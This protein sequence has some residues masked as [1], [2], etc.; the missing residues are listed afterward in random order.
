MEARIKNNDR[1]LK[2]SSVKSVSMCGNSLELYFENPLDSFLAF[3]KMR[4]FG[5]E[6]AHAGGNAPSG[7]MVMLYSHD[8]RLDTQ[9]V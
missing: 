7:P 5:V 1:Y 6:C 3:N 9:F 4:D 8:N 2:I